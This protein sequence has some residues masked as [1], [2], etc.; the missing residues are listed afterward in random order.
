MRH[1]TA[2]IT[3]I[4][5]AALTAGAAA[6][7]AEFGLD[8]VVLVGYLCDWESSVMPAS[9][10]NIRFALWIPSRDRPG[11]IIIPCLARNLKTDDLEEAVEGDMVIVH[12][13]HVWRAGALVILV[14]ELHWAPDVK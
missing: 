4:L 6:Q 7:E 14:E 13:R 2:A 5:V 9:R 11:G 10:S 12:G 8:Q 3:L 1:L